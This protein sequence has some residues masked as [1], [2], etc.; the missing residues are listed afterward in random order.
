M[1]IQVNQEHHDLI[2]KMFRTLD[3]ISET[4]V[5][6]DNISVT[7]ETQIASREQASKSYDAIVDW[8]RYM[9]DRP[10]GITIL[11]S[12]QLKKVITVLRA[13]FDL[14]EITEDSIKKSQ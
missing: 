4:C 6:F 12:F 5:S 2:T 11:N 13:W 7:L 8:Q 10:E 3:D 14:N 9:K 1:A